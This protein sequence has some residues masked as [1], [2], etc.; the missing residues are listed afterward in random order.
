MKEKYSLI[1][2]ADKF[3]EQRQYSKAI[4]VYKS[5][6]DEGD[7]D[8][9]LINNLGDLYLKDG[10]R[11]NALQH[12]VSA[13]N[14]YS[15]SGD[16]LKA[17][18]ICRKVLREDPSNDDILSLLIELNR[19]RDAAL[20]S[21]C[22]LNDMISSSLEQGNLTRAAALQ[23]K[24]AGISSQDPLPR[25]R[26]AEI[27]FSAGLEDSAQKSLL[28]AVKLL[29]GDQ[30]SEQGWLKV[31]RILA[32]RELSPEFQKFVSEVKE[33]SP[34]VGSAADEVGSE[35]GTISPPP[36]PTPSGIEPGP[37]EVFEVESSFFSPEDPTSRPNE[38]ETRAKEYQASEES[39]P[40]SKESMVEGGDFLGSEP[41]G[42]DGT[43]SF[44]LAPGEDQEDSAAFQESPLEEDIPAEVPG[45]ETTTASE[46][47]EETLPGAVES[48][49]GK[50][51]E[52][53]E[54][55]LDLDEVDLSKLDYEALGIEREGRGTGEPKGA[56]P[57]SVRSSGAERIREGKGRPES[58]GPAAEGE[59]AFE[60]E[61]VDSALDGIFSEDQS[62]SSFPSE[63]ETGGILQREYSI[64][65]DA[66]I[67]SSVD[68]H[69]VELKTDHE[70]DPEVQMELG[71]AYF[72]M[73]LF[74]DAQEKFESSL[75]GF[76][77]KGDS[78]K[79][80]FC[81]QRLAECSNGLEE[82]QETLEWVARGLDYREMT[83]EELVRFE[84]ERA[85][86]HQQLG[87]L[88]ESLEGFRRIHE[89]KPD[90]KDVENRISSIEAAGH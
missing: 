66:D 75:A 3:I 81:C 22:L 15:S 58:E 37:S 62:L 87:A 63:E 55:E 85:L 36:P 35:E 27:S 6:V 7:K 13:A 23:K 31:E 34:I 73:G 10:D 39:G 65:A 43:S 47:G 60:L 74:Q 69:Q 28:Y 17:I 29:S 33:G 51:Q 83:D 42:K 78:D 41:E 90:Y 2:S 89:L 77:R 72:E 5:L 32:E 8:P 68:E 12:Y 56:E 14:S 53:A 19:K 49:D 88:S 86:A 71:A 48:G 38:G 21:K 24:L 26:L 40:D 82:Y 80:V 54:F 70:S 16:S 64:G 30:G 50:D 25:I 44:D 1:R 46:E 18:G 20:E 79:C 76:E 4:K 57:E 61:E 67:A 11:G 59:E 9:A 45:A 52:E 84:Y